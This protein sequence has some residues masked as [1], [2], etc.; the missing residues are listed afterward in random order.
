MTCDICNKEITDYY[1]LGDNMITCEEHRDEQAKLVYAALTEEELS[2]VE[3]WLEEEE[4]TLEEVGHYMAMAS[5]FEDEIF[6]TTDEGY[7]EEDGEY[8]G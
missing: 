3:D 1:R 5:V 8:E 7:Y 2:W 4:K 6:W